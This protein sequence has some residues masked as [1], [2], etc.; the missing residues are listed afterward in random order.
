MVSCKPH[1][2]F[3]TVNVVNFRYI[4][5]LLTLVLDHIAQFFCG[6]QSVFESGIIVHY[7]NKSSNV[8][9]LCTTPE[10]EF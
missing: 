1:K 4:H 8:I 9:S 6:I 10:C 2:V 5:E 7:P 3:R